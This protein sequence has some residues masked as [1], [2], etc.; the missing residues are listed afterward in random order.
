VF[1]TTPSESEQNLFNYVETNYVEPN[2]GLASDSSFS[3]YVGVY[4]N[5]SGATT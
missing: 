2:P 1:E 3:G 4:Y 5:D